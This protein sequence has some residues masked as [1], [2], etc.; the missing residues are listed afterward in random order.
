MSTAP[1]ALDAPAAPMSR[2][3]VLESISG[4]ML[5]MLTTIL[6][7]T[8]VSTSLPV[9]VH[10]LGGSQSAYTW[11]VTASLLTMTVTTPIWGKLADLFSRKLLVQIALG[12]FIVSS[13]LAGLSQETWHLITM[14]AFQGVGAGGLMS[15]SMVLIADIISPR[16]R[17][18]YVG[19]LAGVMS[20]GTL[21]GPL[22]GG[23]ITDVIGWRW[24]FYVGVPLALAALVVLQ[25]TLH[26][27]YRERR[28]V[29]IDYL[30]A[31]LIAAGVSTLLLWVSLAG[32][33]FDWL[34]A[35][36]AVL[37][38][39]ALVL[40]ALALRVESRAAEPIIPLALFRN[41]TITLTTIASVTVG[42]GMFGA[43][44]FLAQYM[45]IARDKTPTESGLLTIPLML[46]SL[47]ASTVIGQLVTRT[48]RYKPFMLGGTVSLT[49]GLALL[50]TIDH[51]TSFALLGVYMALVGLGMGS[52]MQNLILAAQNSADIRQMGVAT[53]TVTFFRT[54]GGAIGVAALGAVLSNRVSVLIADG[55][56]ALGGDA[57]AGV[58]G[59][60]PDPS[61]LPPAVREVVERSYAQGV[62]D[63]FLAAVPFG[64]IAIVAIALMPERPLGTKNG[65]QQLAE[66]P[67]DIG[68]DTGAALASR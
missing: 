64:I 10:D 39:G 38:T 12:I 37:V 35:Q 32:R 46:G 26:L 59:S 43:V 8:V 65:I 22:L 61:A 41:R 57:G 2:R 20:I 54:L 25:R 31:V 3:E 49:I 23:V 48:G 30:G 16:E 58:G 50:S 45:Q 36:T 11:V 52:C 6:S 47:V 44:V 7:S 17:G 29:Q 21:G 14:R 1:T 55:L 4:I 5:G 34:S 13:M 56:A 18:K 33:Q 27:P 67:D 60:V 15:L 63:L 51:H 62:S 68:A 28:R 40:L 53:A 66:Q 42:M 24:N 9:I 19:V